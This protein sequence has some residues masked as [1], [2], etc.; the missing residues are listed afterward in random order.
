MSAKKPSTFTLKRV[1]GLCVAIALAIGLLQLIPAREDRAQALT[2]AQ[3]AGDDL[4]AP[5]ADALQEQR[6]WDILNANPELGIQPESLRALVTL[7]LF[8]SA[9]PKPRVQLVLDCSESVATALSKVADHIFT[10]TDQGPILHIEAHDRAGH[11]RVLASLEGVDDPASGTK[12]IGDWRSLLPPVIAILI[13]LF[14]H[15]VLFGMIVAVLTGAV[16]HF[17]GNPIMRLKDGA[18]DYYWGSIADEFSLYIVGF[19][20]ALVG[21][22]IV[23]TRA[24]GSQGVID[25]LTKVAKSAKSTRIATALM[26]LVIFF[27]DYANTIVVGTTVRPMSDRRRISREKLAYLV[28]STAAPIAGLAIISTWIAFEVGI[29]QTLIDQTGIQLEAGVALSGYGLFVAMLPLRLYCLFCLFFVFTGAVSNRDFGPMLRAETRAAKTGEVLAPN[30]RPLTSRSISEILP[31]VGIRYRWH[32]AVVPIVVVIASVLAG[33]LLFGRPSIE[34]A[35]DF[36]VLSFDSWKYAFGHADSGKVL[37]YAALLGSAVVIFL[38][39]SQKILSLPSALVTYSRGVPAMALAIAILI[40]AWAIQSVCGDLGTNVFLVSTVGD[41]IPALIFPLFTFLLAAGI[42]FSTGTS[43]GT[44]GILLPIIL[45]WTWEM[46]QGGDGSV[47]LV[48]LSAAAVLDGAIMGDHCS[49]ISDTTVMSSMASS[50]DHLDHV[51][52]Q[53]PYALSCMAVASVG[54]VLVAAGAPWIVAILTGFALIVVLFMVV[55]KRIPEAPGDP[56]PE[57]DSL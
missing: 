35:H 50:C 39:V 11:M 53:M 52:T 42:A 47:I 14:L 38:A 33:M 40:S 28:D 22:V 17:E 23:A 12:R 15:R 41:S 18:V 44:M 46:T 4:L 21:M 54:Y 34:A 19:T 27:D 37:F 16:L 31:P 25:V 45:P 1:I 9:D 48:L 8:R 7:P 43:W 5:L 3:F 55:G 6:I 36:R 57:T 30:A 13:A 32:I 26:G 10:V 29:L 49:P 51:K 24:G 56:E 20:C 2:V